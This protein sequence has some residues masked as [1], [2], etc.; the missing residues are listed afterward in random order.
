[1]RQQGV[2]SRQFC[3]TFDASP[4]FHEAADVFALKTFENEYLVSRAGQEGWLEASEISHKNNESRVRKLFGDEL[5]QVGNRWE[6]VEGARYGLPKTLMVHEVTQA[7]L[8]ELKGA[9]LCEGNQVLGF[10]PV[11]APLTGIEL[12]HM[13]RKGQ[14]P[15]S[16]TCSV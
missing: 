3:A 10:L 2:D 6:M 4:H 15:S 9:R 5:R 16:A 14:M 1:M 7:T 11:R 8:V 13:I 12:L